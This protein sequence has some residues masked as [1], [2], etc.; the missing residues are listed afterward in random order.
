M[1]RVE[2]A[3][4][5]VVGAGLLGLATAPPVRSGSTNAWIESPNTT[6]A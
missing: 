2:R 3:E 4:A 1:T 6:A 5:V